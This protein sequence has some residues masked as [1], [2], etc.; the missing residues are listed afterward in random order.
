MGMI[1]I[2]NERFFFKFY[3]NDQKSISRKVELPHYCTGRAK[4]LS[5]L[6][7]LDPL[8]PNRHRFFFIFLNLLIYYCCLYI[9]LLK[10]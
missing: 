4:Y 7:I 10:N 3:E 9:H 5:R 8:L 6:L 2:P 1:Y